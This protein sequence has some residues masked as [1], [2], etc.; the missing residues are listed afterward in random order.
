MQNNK[1]SSLGGKIGAVWPKGDEAI[2]PFMNRPSLPPLRTVPRPRQALPVLGTLLVTA[3]AHLPTPAY[4]EP[5]WVSPLGGDY[6]DTTRWE[7]G[8]LPTPG[9]AVSFAATPGPAAPYTV[10]FTGNVNLSTTGFSRWQTMV[11]RVTFRM[12]SGS[13]AYSLGV[14]SLEVR[15]GSMR[16]EGGAINI[17]S[18]ILVGGGTGGSAATLT[19]SNGVLLT[20]T[21]TADNF[22]I[23]STATGAGS[24]LQVE[25]G[26]KII[27][28]ERLLIGSGASGNSATITGAGSSVSAT[29]GIYVG[30]GTNGTSPNAGFANNS[31]E[32]LNGAEASTP[33]AVYVG[34]Y[35]TAAGNSL[36]IDGVG[37]KL[38]AAGFFRV[39]TADATST[40]NKVTVSNSGKLTAS[41]L[42]Q[43]AV[44]NEVRLESG[45]TI[46]QSN[47]TVNNSIRGDLVVDGGTFSGASLNF[48]DTGT[49]QFL[50]GEV[51]FTH[52]LTLEGGVHFTFALDPSLTVEV[53]GNL[54]LQNSM[55]YIDLVNLGGAAP[56]EYTLFNFGGATNV[57]ASFLQLG[58][59][60]DGFEGN[61]VFDTDR[62]LL[63]VVAVPEPGA[64]LA[65]AAAGLA[66]TY[67][68]RRRAPHAPRL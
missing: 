51:S 3:A 2:V 55:N 48:R 20:D 66:F 46:T 68:R 64:L 65:T 19:L 22:K 35:A 57:N 39:G 59:T 12:T 43:V 47:T 8:V 9:S 21:G 37:S 60:P 56:G 45:G 31:L 24:H 23:G 29:R 17:S 25:G 62:V 42:F 67:F 32:I 7:G 30:L 49:L 28:S 13:D 36:L 4:A 41:N 58:I 44:G 14:S 11:D 10:Q 26:S 15:G 16:F 54:V 18:Q 33:G 61:L 5:T 1:I 53:A 27:S 63:N 34:Y 50:D 6:N 38:S 52:N 40:G